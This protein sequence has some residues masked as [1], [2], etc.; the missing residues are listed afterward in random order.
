MFKCIFCL[1][2]CGC[3]CKYFP[4]L[5]CDLRATSSTVSSAFHWREGSQKNRPMKSTI[6]LHSHQLGNQ[7]MV[8]FPNKPLT[9]LILGAFP[10]KL[11][12]QHQPRNKYHRWKQTPLTTPVFVLLLVLSLHVCCLSLSPPSSPCDL[13]FTLQI[14]CVYKCIRLFWITGEQLESKHNFLLMHMH[15][16]MYLNSAGSKWSTKI[17]WQIVLTKK[18]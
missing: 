13:V 7:W 17:D 5:F 2:A 18:V 12:T 4:I 10:I 1:W 3:V 11:V 6:S 8:C 9:A 14:F 15:T 16:S